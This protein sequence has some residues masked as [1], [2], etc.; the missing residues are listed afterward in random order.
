MTADLQFEVLSPSS[1]A[2]VF[3]DDGSI[4]QAAASIAAIL[5]PVRPAAAV[6]VGVAAVASVHLPAVVVSGDI[7]VNVVWLSA[8]V[9]LPG[10]ASACVAT[11]DAAVFR[12]PA[13]HLA[14]Q[15]SAASASHIATTV[16]MQAAQAVAGSIACSYDAMPPVHRRAVAVQAALTTTS[17]RVAARVSAPK[18][19]RHIRVIGATAPATRRELV[20]GVSFGDAVWA[21]SN[22]ICGHRDMA[23]AGRYV[24]D[25]VRLAIA[26]HRG[27]LDEYRPAAG[28]QIY[29][30]ASGRDAIRPPAGISTTPIDPP[31]AGCCGPR[32]GH[33]RFLVRGPSG[34]HL[35]FRCDRDQLV[36]GISIPVQRVYVVIND[37][38]L[39]RADDGT[40][41]DCTS[42][43]LSADVDSWAWSWRATISA[44]DQAKLAPA[45][46]A[47]ACEL[48]AHV[49]GQVWRVIVESAQRDREW[50][51]AS[52][53]IGGRSASAIWDA[54]Y[55]AQRTFN[56][57]AVGAMTQ[58]LALDALATNGVLS[59]WAIDWQVPDWLVP[60]GVWSH[61]GTPISA[62]CRIA[63]AAGGYVQSAPAGG[64]L[65][66]L[67][68]YLAAPW[69]WDSLV[70]DI[71]LPADVVRQEGIEW[72]SKAIY[73]RAFVSGTTAGGVLGRV[74]RAATAGDLVAP[75]ITDA[76]CTDVMAARARALPVLSDVG[77]QAMVQLRLPVLAQTG[78][79]VPGKLVQYVD[80]DLTRLG[81]TRSLSIQA[82]RASV[83]QTIG[84]QT[85]E[86]F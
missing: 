33:L 15:Y 73:N 21:G 72:V 12:G 55:A 60:A 41:I 34:P 61:Q 38:Q 48:L 76:L 58:Q 14:V 25:Q 19:R 47:A 13:C 40:A 1:R 31:I 69:A 32:N 37:V 49:N 9:H 8:S 57:M 74:T 46:G 81:M 65:M 42:L 4:A 44:R 64:R 50:S 66:V 18:E 3:G 51:K 68:R 71:E 30:V 75:M 16:T 56:N 27:V 86:Q 45:A 20:V 79:I 28:M 11:Y 17:G 10:V 53:S 54:P 29:L 52:L 22:A 82:G 59:N 77:R 5:A 63:E 24:T 80:G 7:E 78:A 35:I 62:I 23:R 83:W 36:P 84:V 70:P 67:P 2:L 26:M 43:T 6:A 85:Y 39:V